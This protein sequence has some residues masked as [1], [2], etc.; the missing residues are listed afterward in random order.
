MI[1]NLF[2]NEN[3]LKKGK[4]AKSVHSLFSLT[5]I[6]IT[7]LQYPILFSVSGFHHVS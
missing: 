6:S 4:Y 7:R 1:C 5:Y 3:I 2:F